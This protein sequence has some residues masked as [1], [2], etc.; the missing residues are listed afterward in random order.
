MPVRAAL[1]L[2]YFLIMEGRDEKQ[3]KEAD[4]K[5]YG[6]GEMNEQANRKLRMGGGEG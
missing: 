3:R 4:E 5:L 1:N 6:W 2:A